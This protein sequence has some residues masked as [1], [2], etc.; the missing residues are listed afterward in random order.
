MS[1]RHE[2]LI[3]SLRDLLRKVLVAAGVTASTR[4]DIITEL[5][6]DHRTGMWPNIEGYG[7]ESWMIG[8]YDGHA[9]GLKAA[10]T[11][12][13]EQAG[14]AFAAGKDAEALVLRKLAD[15]MTASIEHATEAARLQR[16]SRRD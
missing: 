14:A 8:K 3:E 5:L 10:Q 9:E 2:E 13:R 7:S 12:L 11:K 15:G 6:G 16:A 1:R 4:K